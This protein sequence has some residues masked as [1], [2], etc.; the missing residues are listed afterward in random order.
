MPYDEALA[1]RV[2]E[3]ISARSELKELKMFGVAGI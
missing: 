2:R 3:Q 1:D